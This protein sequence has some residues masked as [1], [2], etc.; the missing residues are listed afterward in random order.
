MTGNVPS[1]SFF[2]NGQNP[3]PAT[4]TLDATGT[5]LQIAP[6]A[7]LAPATQYCYYVSYYTA[8]RGTNGVAAPALTACFTTGTGSRPVSATR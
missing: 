3:V 4:V 1:V 6:S 7:L 2:G 5:V 8:I